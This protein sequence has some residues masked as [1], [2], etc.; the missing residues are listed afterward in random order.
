M[1]QNLKDTILDNLTRA[2]NIVIVVAKPLGFDGIA[3]GLAL[4]LS[5]IKLDKNVTVIAKSPTVGDA[6]NLYGIDRIGR[7]EGTRN[8][9]IVVDNAVETVDKVTY[10]LDK[11][12]L[13]VVIHPLPGTQEITKDQISIDYISAPAS[14]VLAI[15][16]DNL[17]DLRSEFTHEQEISP[18]AWIVNISNL[19]PSQ[20]FA[21]IDVVN[22]EAASVSEVTAKMLQDLA[23]PVDEDIAFNLYSGIRATTDN[24]SPNMVSPVSFELASWL[25]KFGAGKASLARHDVSPISSA[26]PR[27]EEIPQSVDFGRYTPPIEEVERQPQVPEVPKSGDWLKPPK[28]YKGSKSFNGENK[29]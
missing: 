10:F 17:H 1:D 27:I 25:L 23:L 22:T 8:P 3:A 12:K 11:T 29:G 13:K 24:F 14:A 4:Y 28:I 26:M 16:V 5:L 2:Q 7:A 6:Q 15:G 21:Q 19:Q 20:K 9:V 18:D